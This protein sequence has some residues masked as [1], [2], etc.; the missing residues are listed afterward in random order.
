[1][2]HLFSNNY[3]GAAPL[4]ARGHLFDG[5]AGFAL[6]ASLGAMATFAYGMRAPS[7]ERWLKPGF[8]L[9]GFGLIVVANIVYA[10]LAGVG[11]GALWDGIVLE[12]ARN[13]AGGL[14]L[15]FRLG[16]VECAATVAVVVAVWW[17]GRYRREWLGWLRVAAGVATIFLLVR[18]DLTWVLPLVP[19]GVI[20][21]T[22]REW[23]PAEWFTR[24]FVADLAVTEFLQ[25]YP[26]AGGQ[27]GIAALP[28]M[29]W[30]FVCVWDGFEE[31]AL[32][33]LA[34]PVGALVTVAVT[35]G[36]WVS[37]LKQFG[38]PY[39]P[40]QLAG[41]SRLHLE[42]GQ[43]ATY[44]FLAGSIRGN[45][46]VLYTLPRLN[47]LNRWSGVPPPA[48]SESPLS[49]QL[50]TP[51]RQQRVLNALQQDPSSCAVY[52][53]EILDFW[54]APTGVVEHSPLAQYV[55]REMPVMAS[56]AGYEI[57]VHPARREPWR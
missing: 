5:A 38:L 26:V 14:F 15:G 51:E 2:R 13:P 40:S 19:L 36:M 50:Y 3:L 47:S 10:Q 45:C 33:R 25:T 54:Q 48:G 43:A 9:S 29:L 37:G 41:S 31:L 34:S 53:R 46:R 17:A 44:R 22:R 56:R 57:R 1:M 21:L 28:V 12:P 49:F 16:W 20:P 52:S 24:I 6:V 39:P 11:I 4:L 55:I 27:S 8:L 42:P 18:T 35:A 7:G 30:A 32:T 23:S